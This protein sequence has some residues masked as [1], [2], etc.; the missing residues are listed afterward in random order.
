MTKRKF[1]AKRAVAWRR[2]EEL[3]ERLDT[4]SLRRFTPAETAEFSRLFRELCHDLS[5]IRSRDWVGG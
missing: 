2:F 4:V 3:L 5:L 1:L